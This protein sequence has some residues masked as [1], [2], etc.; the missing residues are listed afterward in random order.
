MTDPPHFTQ[1]Y[2]RPG[3]KLP[4]LTEPIRVDSIVY[5]EACINY[6][7]VH[8]TDR[9]NCLAAK[10]LKWV[11][12]QLPVFI[13]IHDG[14]LINPTHVAQVNEQGPR[15]LSVQLTN[16][17]TLAVARRRIKCVRRQLD[18]LV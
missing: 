16:G 10:T 5:V 1:V 8:F 18:E 3:L 12:A 4:G 15:S 9:P 6:C 17:L 2:P 7:W 13:R 14:K 11:Q